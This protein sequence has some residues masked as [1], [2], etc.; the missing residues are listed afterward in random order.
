MLPVTEAT[1]DTIDSQDGSRRKKAEVSGTNCMSNEAGSTYVGAADSIDD[2]DDRPLSA[3]FGGMQCPPS[4]SELRKL[5][6]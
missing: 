4:V 3:W 2:D 5:L 1:C 6:K